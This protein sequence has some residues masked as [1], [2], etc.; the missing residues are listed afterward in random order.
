MPHSLGRKSEHL[1]LRNRARKEEQEHLMLGREEV[2][3]SPPNDDSTNMVT[4]GSGK[5]L[6]PKCRRCKDKPVISMIILLS[7][8]QNVPV[9]QKLFYSLFSSPLREVGADCMGWPGQQGPTP[10]KGSR[11]K[12]WGLQQHGAHFPTMSLGGHMALQT[13]VILQGSGP[14]IPHSPPWAS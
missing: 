2:A 14:G 10:A 6:P 5:G 8:H 12:A 13:L 3:S 9:Q 4:G 1:I 11:P 7:V